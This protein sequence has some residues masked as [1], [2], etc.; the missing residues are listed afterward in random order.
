VCNHAIAIF[1]EPNLKRLEPHRALDM[2]SAS[3]KRWAERSFA[4]A[5]RALCNTLHVDRERVRE[6]EPDLRD[7]TP[8]IEG[9]LPTPGIRSPVQTSLVLFLR[10]LFTVVGCRGRTLW[11]DRVRGCIQAW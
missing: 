6:R 5:L 8:M 2:C 11:C 7:A 4:F 1:D 3:S 10:A 9:E